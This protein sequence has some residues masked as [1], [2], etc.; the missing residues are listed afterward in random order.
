MPSGHPG[1]VREP[2]QPPEGSPGQCARPLPQDTGAGCCVLCQTRADVCPQLRGTGPDRAP[3][4]A[5]RAQ[6]GLCMPGR[7]SACPGR[8]LRARDGLCMPGRCSACPGRALCAGMVLCV[9][10]TGSAC[11]DS[12][13]RA[14]DGLCVP[15][16]CSACPGWALR[17]PLLALLTRG[18]TGRAPGP[19][20]CGVPTL[21]LLVPVL[22][23]G[24]AAQLHTVMSASLS[25]GQGFLSPQRTAAHLAAPPLGCPPL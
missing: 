17:I 24:Q 6:D 5:L 12:A 16:R 21:N 13:L 7:C 2:E 11:R 3:D 9:P 25:G 20:V 22:L 10:G 4:G 1:P 15:G 8:A 19:L 18:A 23:Q 14:W